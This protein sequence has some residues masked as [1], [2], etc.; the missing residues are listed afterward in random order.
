MIIT[1]DEFELPILVAEK[2]QEVADY[3]GISKDH[4]HCLIKRNIKAR[5]RYRVIK[6]DL[7]EKDGNEN[8]I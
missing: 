8:D 2:I 4:A 1:A 3:F 6:F 5:R 7:N